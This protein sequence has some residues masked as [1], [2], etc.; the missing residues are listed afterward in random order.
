LDGKK[1]P[2]NVKVGIY[3]LLGIVTKKKKKNKKQTPTTFT[4][5]S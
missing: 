3:E 2:D 5:I 1:K 4:P